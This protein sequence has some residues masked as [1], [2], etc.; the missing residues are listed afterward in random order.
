MK[1]YSIHRPIGPGT[2]PKFPDNHV[3]EI[4]NFDYME[5]VSEIGRKAWGYIVYEKPID[6][7]SAMSYELMCKEDVEDEE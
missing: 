6:K 3:L 2:F 4:Y 1:Y 5:N 7:K